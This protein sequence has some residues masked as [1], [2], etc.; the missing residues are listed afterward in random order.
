MKAVVVGA[1][2]A[3]LAAAYALRKAGAEVTVLEERE[4]PGGRIAGSRKEGFVLEAGAQFLFRFYDS[5]FHLCRE[6][7]LGERLKPFPFKVAGWKE[8]RLYP[9][10]FSIDPRALWRDRRD[11]FRFR[12]FSPRGALQVARL[13]SLAFRRRRDLHFVDYAGMLDLDGESLSELALRRGGREALERLMQPLAS[14]LTLGEPEEIGAGY[15][16]ALAWYALNGV[17]ALEGGIGTLAE[18]LCRACGENI[19]LS[20][21][22][23]RIAIEGGAVK[24]VETGEGFFDAD[25]VICATTAT[26]ALR[27]MPGLPEGVRRA[28]GRARY[29]ACCHVMLALP[30]PLLPEGWY[31]VALPRSSRSPPSMPTVMRTSCPFPQWTMLAD[32]RPPSSSQ[33]SPS[34]DM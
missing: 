8:G 33:E 4:R 1:G 11:L 15:G 26:R 21:P 12:L 19:M 7:G 30:R 24:G 13:L 23:L 34:R 27:L 6:L 29:S 31:A 16:L 25:A 14:C 3:G 18:G 10:T 17:F 2:T 9:L 5:A 32:R 20:T 22:A 28:L